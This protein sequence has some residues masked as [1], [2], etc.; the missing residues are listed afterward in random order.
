MW[1]SELMQ[2]QPGWI[3]NISIPVS[4]FYCEIFVAVTL[5]FL[6]NFDFLF[7]I[8]FVNGITECNGGRKSPCMQSQSPVENTAQGCN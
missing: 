1:V 7:F 4:H 5:L 8:W 3:N 6:D 2:L